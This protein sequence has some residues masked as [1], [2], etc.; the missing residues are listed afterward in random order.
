MSLIRRAFILLLPAAVLVGFRVPLDAQSGGTRLARFEGTVTIAREDADSGVAIDLLRWST[1][2][3]RTEMEKALGEGNDQ[4]VANALD[5][6]E[7]LGYVWTAESVGYAIRYAYHTPIDN[8]GE[9]IIL[10]LNGRFGSRNPTLWDTNQPDGQPY[11]LLELR[12]DAQGRGEGRD[13]LPTAMAYAF[14]LDGYEVAPTL[15]EILGRDN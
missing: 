10:A 15:L 5:N 3:E 7:T 12:V 4:S 13:V 1:D 8:G 6:T 9:R 2:E 11:T 14:G